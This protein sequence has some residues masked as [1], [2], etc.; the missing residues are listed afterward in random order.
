MIGE[1]RLRIIDALLEGRDV[2]LTEFFESAL[3]IESLRAGPAG[4]L[5][6]AFAQALAHSGYA[7]ITARRHIRSAEHFVYWANR[8]GMQVHGPN[9]PALERFDR[10]LRR[11]GQCPHFGHTFRLQILHGTRLFLTH[12]HAAGLIESAVLERTAPDPPLIVAF[13]RWMHE[14]RGTCESTLANYAVHLRELLTRVGDEPGTWTAQSLRQFVL[15]G[16][17]TCGWAAAKKRTTA[18]RMFLRFLIAEGQC[19]TGLEGA[20]PVLAH[21]RLSSLPRYLPAE[22]VERVIA[23]CDR[24]SPIGTRDRAILLLL[25][26]LGLRAGD[27]VQLRRDDIDWKGASIRVRGKGRRETRLPLTDEVGQAVVAYLRDGRP[28]TETETLFVRCR[29]PFRAFRSHCAVSV[30]VD[31]A[32]SRTGVVRPSRGAAHL[33]RHSVATSML[34]HGASLQEV[35]ALLRHRSIATTQI[36][37]K[38]DVTALRTI[39]QPWPEVSSC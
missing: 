23:S 1:G 39:A 17:R 24:T 33:L 20:I 8:A 36:Y 5:L 14:Q 10:H 35:G 30:I 26:R 11:G 22:E 21:W 15:E 27:I 31:R 9:G 7:E 6:E 38:V 28:Q 4:R 12:L 16:S 25:A 2:M 34:R 19:A 29:A 32:F 37:A 3:R 18:L 13:D